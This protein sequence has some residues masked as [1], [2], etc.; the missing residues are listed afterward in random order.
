MK[1]TFYTL[2]GFIFFV[3]ICSCNNSSQTGNSVAQSPIPNSTKSEIKPD[4]LFDGFAKLISGNIEKIPANVDQTYYDSFSKQLNPKL[5]EIEKTR[6]SPI[7]NWNQ[8][9]LNRNAKSDTT[10]VFYPFSGGDFLHVNS[11][12]PNAN[13]YVMM[14]QESVGSIPDLTKM[15]KVQT[16]EYIKAAD[17][18]LRDIYAKSYFI[19]MNMIKDTKSSPVNGMLPVLLWS[20]SKTGHTVTAVDELSV[21]EN[22]KKTY[23]PFKVGQNSAKAVRISF[24]NKEKGILKTL[25]YYSCDISDP[26]IEKDKALAATLEALPPSNCFVKSASYLMHYGTFTKIRNTVLEKAIYLVQD[27]TGIPYR[28]FDKTKFKMELYGNYVK[29]VSDFSENLYQKEMVDAYKTREF[30]GV[31]PFSLGYHWQTKDQNQ[32]IAVKK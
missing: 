25:T 27:D 19:T 28:Y 15:D 3:F 16:K 29:P 6:L 31:L 8:A 26:G 5:E 24:G 30:M 4:E 1:I 13:H 32:M 21:D 9:A 14:A 12:Y 10:S 7:T 2:S 20:V 22:G 11:L 17:F 18:I 23:T